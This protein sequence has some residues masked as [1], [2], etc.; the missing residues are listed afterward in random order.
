MKAYGVVGDKFSRLRILLSRKRRLTSIEP[1]LITTASLPISSFL[2]RHL[3]FP[4]FLDACQDF[5][6][7][8][9][10]LLPL[11]PLCREVSRVLADAY[12]RRVVIVDT[13]NEIGGDGDIPHP[14]IGRA[15]RMQVPQVEMQHQ[16]RIDWGQEKGTMRSRGRVAYVKGIPCEGS[17][18]PASM[19]QPCYSHATAMLQPCYSQH[20]PAIIT[21][22]LFRPTEQEQSV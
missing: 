6:I 21:C 19:L 3:H 20:M 17:A 2:L 15:R 8:G 12:L 7:Q 10:H 14:G 5:G 16:V 13:S 22:T 1:F 9:P 4:L 18:V 11:P